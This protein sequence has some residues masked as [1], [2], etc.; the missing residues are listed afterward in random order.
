MDNQLLAA[1]KVLNITGRVLLGLYFIVPGLSK[2]V[3]FESTSE[4]MALHNVPLIPLLLV[5]TIILQVA[6]GA[7]LLLGYRTQ[8]CAFL[9]AGLTLLISLFMHNFWSYEEGLERA[10]E[11]QNFIKNLA[12]MA[13]LLF[14]SGT[15]PATAPA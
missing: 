10:H 7:S 5:I 14:V 4:Y 11:M 3:G 9:L 6:G 12:I 2:I 1:E 13:G 8:L 15:R